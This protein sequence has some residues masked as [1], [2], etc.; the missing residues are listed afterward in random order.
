MDKQQAIAECERWLAYLDRQRER[1]TALQRLASECR[2]DLGKDDARRRLAQIDRGVTV[3][4]G[5]NLEQA[6]RFLLGKIKDLD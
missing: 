4:D 6:V 3:Y 5:S 1:S 2:A